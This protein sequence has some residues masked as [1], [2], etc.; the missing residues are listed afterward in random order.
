L[1]DNAMLGRI[2]KLLAMAEAEGLTDAARETYNT[3]AAEL[4][5]RYG[6]DAA[7]LT[8]TQ[9][10]RDEPAD[11]R[12][13]LEAPYA[14]DKGDLLN[15]VAVALR[16][17]VVFTRG[18]GAHLF[19]MASDVE[20]VELLYTSLMVQ[21]ALGLAGVRPADPREDVRAYRRSWMAGFRRAVY[22][23][24][25]RAESAA[26]VD[27]ERRQ[28]D[29]GGRSVALVLA[30]RKALV[31]RAVA[32]AYPQLRSGRSRQLSGS[33]GSAGY[34]A[35]QRADLGGARVGGSGRRALG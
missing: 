19:G 15:Y 16:C 33:G 11:R 12:V 3:K 30:D 8:E 4:I 23:R 29:A 21:Q 25:N 10:T 17:R 18:G 31:D 6:I 5:A 7:L 26:R 24:L 34:A 2:R 14:K 20:R 28:A 13:T 1:T 22:E 32:D 27:G 35:G 9:P